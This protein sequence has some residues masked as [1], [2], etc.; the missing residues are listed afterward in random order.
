MQSMATLHSRKTAPS[1]QGALAASETAKGQPGPIPKG[2]LELSPVWSDVQVQNLDTKTLL[3]RHEGKGRVKPRIPTLLG[4]HRHTSQLSAPG[5][6]WL[7]A[8]G[9]PASARGLGVT[10]LVSP[11]V[12]APYCEIT[13]E[14]GWHGLKAEVL[15]FLQHRT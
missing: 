8:R 5:G 12:D 7:G 4:R 3:H 10:N 2:S 14:R 1:A 11:Q 15:Q 9:P 13:A 6:S